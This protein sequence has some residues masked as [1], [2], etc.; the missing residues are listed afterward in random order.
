M[1]IPVFQF[2]IIQLYLYLKLNVQL[3]GSFTLIYMHLIVHSLFEMIVVLSGIGRSC[4]IGE[5]VS[6]P[7]LTKLAVSGRDMGSSDCRERRGNVGSLRSPEMSYD[8]GGLRRHWPRF[9]DQDHS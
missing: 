5:S 1:F 7:E 2:S 8:D 3:C 6:V 4:P 9:C